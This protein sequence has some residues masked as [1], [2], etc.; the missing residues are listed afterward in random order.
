[1]NYYKIR[2][3]LKGRNYIALNRKGKTEQEAIDSII[4]QCRIADLAKGQIIKPQVKT[5]ERTYKN[6]PL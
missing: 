4:E 2:F 6:S 5:V 1:M 3:T